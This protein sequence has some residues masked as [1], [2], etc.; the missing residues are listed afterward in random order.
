[1]VFEWIGLG[2]VLV[3]VALFATEIIH[4]GALLLIPGSVLIVAGLV[5][6]LF[7]DSTL[8]S[9]PG[10][11]AVSVAAIL[12]A[13]VELPLYQRVAP[14]HRPMTTTSSGLAG[15]VGVVIAPVVPDTLSGKVR[16]KSEVWSAR[17]DAPISNGTRV[18]VVSGEGVAVHVTPIADEPSGG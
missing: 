18:R 13:A 12:A 7:N 16:I 1:M 9:I 4:P 5:A 2:L 15:E 14:T 17:A 8:T 10:I 6:L 11:L 3:G